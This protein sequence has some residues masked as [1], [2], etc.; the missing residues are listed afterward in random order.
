[1]V[2]GS[3]SIGDD[4]FNK[5]INFLYSTV[6]AL[7]K[8]GA[9]GTQVAMVQFT[10]DPRTE[11]KLDAYK[12]KETLL[13]AIRHISYKG[14]NTKTGYNIFAIGVADADYSELVRI[15]SKPS[16]RHVF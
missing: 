6:G 3:W 7:D 14:G 2:D 8:I 15:G 1:M 4:N 11:F 12:T 16:S 9:D 5:I 13:D 10:D